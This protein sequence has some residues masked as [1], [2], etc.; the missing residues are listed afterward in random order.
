MYNCLHLLLLI[1]LVYTSTKAEVKLQINVY[2]S[3][4]IYIIK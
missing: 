3:R 1:I 2:L 4:Y